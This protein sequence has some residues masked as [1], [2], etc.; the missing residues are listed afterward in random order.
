M[1]LIPC[2]GTRATHQA[3]FEEGLGETLESK[4][5]GGFRQ[6]KIAVLHVSKDGL[7]E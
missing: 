7:L 1:T 5:T 2:V 4:T 6:D 3:R